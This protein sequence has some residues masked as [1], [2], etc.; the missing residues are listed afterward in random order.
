MIGFYE[1]FSPRVD[2]LRRMSCFEASK[3][4]AQSQEFEKVGV[5]EIVNFIEMEFKY[6]NPGD[7]FVRSVDIMKRH[8]K[9][10]LYYGV[11]GWYSSA[12]VF[13]VVSSKYCGNANRIS[14]LILGEESA[15]FIFPFVNDV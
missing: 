15:S 10:L 2:L 6:K 11:P 12:V 1:N 8:R 13:S 5:K 9:E 4:I 14:V 7:R 3:W